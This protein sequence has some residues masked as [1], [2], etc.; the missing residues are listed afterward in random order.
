M[1]S[2]LDRDFSAAALFLLSAMVSGNDGLEPARG[3]SS[4]HCF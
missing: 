1:I 4:S 2:F 3:D